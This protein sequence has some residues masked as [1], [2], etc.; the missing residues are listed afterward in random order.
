MSNK[1]IWDGDGHAMEDLPSIAKRLRPV[2]RRMAKTG[3]GIFPQF[4]HFKVPP[5]LLPPGTFQWTV[6]AKEW[7]R[8]L[9]D[10][11][12]EATIMYPTFG[13]AFGRINNEDWA[14]D[15]ARAYNDWLYESHLSKS[16]RL[17][18][19]G[20]IPMQEPEAAVKELRR[21]VKEFGMCGAMLTSTGLKSHLGS[22]E[23]WPVYAEA[24]RLGC[25]L[26]VHGGAHSGLG[27]DDFNHNAAAHALGHPLGV[28]ISF[29]AMLSNGIFDRFPRLRLAFLEGG[30]GWLIMAME[31]LSGS[32]AA[33]PPAD[34]RKLSIQLKKG[35]S[36]ADYI[37][38]QVKAGR[39]FIGCEGDEPALGL[40]A[41]LAGAGAWVY[42]S[43]YPHEVTPQSCKR[44]IEELLERED[45]SKQEKGAILSG[46][47]KRLYTRSTSPTP[48]T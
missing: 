24:E 47:A 12:I 45:L 41:K 25:C 44:E 15:V 20:L 11:G 23:Y 27:F 7:M 46:N 42:S 33:H 43:D 48:Y 18:G 17:K 31:R 5:G 6:G 30:A 8:F 9:D 39:L 14:I 10:V 37:R 40:G 28:V 19:M 21:I 38:R 22:R 32:F 1:T 35:E 2:H 16:K 29:V 26:A 4:D 34:P 3:T 36:V 13:L